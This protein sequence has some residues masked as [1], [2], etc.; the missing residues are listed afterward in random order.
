MGSERQVSYLGGFGAD[1]LKPLELHSTLP[2][3][4]ALRLQRSHAFS[5]ARLGGRA[6]PLVLPQRHGWFS[7][8]PAL[9]ASQTYPWEFAMSI[10]DCVALARL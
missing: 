8:A 1:S 10:C 2:V 6:Q 5:I 7:A 3:H 4:A 9:H